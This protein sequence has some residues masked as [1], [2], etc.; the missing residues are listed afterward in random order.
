MARLVYCSTGPSSSCHLYP[1]AKLGGGN[2]MKRSIIGPALC[3]AALNLGACAAVTRGDHT[4][5]EINTTPPGASVKTTNDMECE[6]TPCSLKMARRSE[7]D[8]TVTKAGFKSVTF[9]VSHKIGTGGGVGMAG[10]VILGGVIG[11][12]V[13]VATGAMYDLTPNPVNLTLE[14]DETSVTSSA[15]VSGEAASTSGP[16]GMQTTSPS[17]SAAPGK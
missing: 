2:P 11:A 5:W 1:G 14:K 15:P 4:A 6:S 13:D 12:G 3:V 16:V 8:A 7:F 10:N 17:A 9:H